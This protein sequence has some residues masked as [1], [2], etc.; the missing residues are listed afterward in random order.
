MIIVVVSIT[1]CQG[2]NSKKAKDSAQ[3]AE[4]KLLIDGQRYFFLAQSMYP[5]R[6]GMR[7]LTV[8][9][10]LK[11]TKDTLKSE[12]PYFGRAYQAGYGSEGALE[13]TSLEFDY[14]TAKGKKNTWE[15]TITPKDVKNCREMILTIYEN[16]SADLKVLSNEKESISFKG[17][18]AASKN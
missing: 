3:T 12:L 11:V 5:N 7:Q 9:Y 2:Q 15:I 13:F 10:N 17:N 1:V 14:K 8:G 18:I 16:G 4:T 6:G